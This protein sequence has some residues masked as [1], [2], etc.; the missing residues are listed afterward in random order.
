MLSPRDAESLDELPPV[1]RDEVRTALGFTHVAAVFVEGRPVS[2]G[3]AGYET[4]KYFDVSIDTLE[5]FRGR[6]YGRDCCE[7]LIDHMARHGLEP[8]WGAL[9]G[10]AASRALAASLGF[11]PVGEVVVFEAPA[12]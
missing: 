10:N 5:E 12:A 11:R 4:E 2:F 7:F 3:Y 1:L 8:V 6:G 9:E